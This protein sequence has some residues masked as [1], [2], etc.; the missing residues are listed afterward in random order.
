MKMHKIIK[1]LK[2][3]KINENLKL[4]FKIYK[5]KSIP[6]L[7]IKPAKIILANI[8]A[9]TWTLGNHIWKPKVGILTIPTKITKIKISKILT[10]LKF[11][12]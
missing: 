11:K 2:N 4:K 3:I 1:T 8:G 10:K 7:S 9:S 5:T 12:I 6:P